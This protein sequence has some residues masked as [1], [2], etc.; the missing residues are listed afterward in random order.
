MISAAQQNKAIFRLRPICVLSRVQIRVDFA[1]YPGNIGMWGPQHT[2]LF[3]RMARLGLAWN[4]MRLC[5]L[6]DD[7]PATGSRRGASSLVS[8][9]RPTGPCV[10]R[11]EWVT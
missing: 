3:A 1:G 6:R 7:V 8:G 4:A 11:S 10:P 9:S 2:L 5:R